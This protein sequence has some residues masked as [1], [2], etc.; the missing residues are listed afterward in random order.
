MTNKNKDLQ[1]KIFE[2][3]LE[4]HNLT[5]LEGEINDIEH[6]VNAELMKEFSNVY[7]Q[8][9]AANTAATANLHLQQMQEKEL[10]ETAKQYNAVVEQN[11]QLQQER[12][13]LIS[14]NNFI[15]SELNQIKLLLEGKNTECEEL[16]KAAF[17]LAE[18]LNFRQKN[19]K[20]LKLFAMHRIF[21]LTQQLGTFLKS[22]KK[23]RKVKND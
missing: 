7:M 21:M 16:K 12:M 9:N 23:Q 5:L 17:T 4:Q 18:G 11:R 13:Q 20:R 8:L 19:W 3:F 2:Y 6:L 1:Q 14:N 10:E 22:S 15:N